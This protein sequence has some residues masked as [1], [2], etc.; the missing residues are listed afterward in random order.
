MESPRTSVVIS[1]RACVLRERRSGV[2]Y[3]VVEEECTGCKRCL[4]L[5]CPALVMRGDKAV[6]QEDL[7]VGCSLCAQVCR[8]GA[9]VEVMTD[10]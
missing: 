9:L 8:P 5:G 3:K 10:G 7:C 4:R 6:V 1:R 2:V